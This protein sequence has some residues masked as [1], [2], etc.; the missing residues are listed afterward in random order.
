MKTCMS[1]QRSRMRKGHPF[2]RRDRKS[3]DRATAPARRTIPE[4]A[5]HFTAS[6][7]RKGAR[8]VWFIFFSFEF[9]KRRSSIRAVASTMP[10]IGLLYNQSRSLKILDQR[11]QFEDLFL[12]SRP[13]SGYLLS[14]CENKQRMQMDKKYP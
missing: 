11:R 6:L 7:G 1:G 3:A 13:P 10:G 9:G 12:D 14:I 8:S 2:Q 4:A 5:T